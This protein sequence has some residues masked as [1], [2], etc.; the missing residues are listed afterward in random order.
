M[1][2]EPWTKRESETQKAYSRFCVYRDM[3]PDRSI[4]KVCEE[5]GKPSGYSRHL[6]RWSSEHNWVSRAESYD[7]Y[8]SERMR[9]ELE[10]K[11]IHDKV[12]RLTSLDSL[13]HVINDALDDLDGSDLSP[14]MLEKL[15]KLV[16]QEKRKEYDD[17]PTQRV[18]GE[19]DQVTTF[20]LPDNGRYEDHE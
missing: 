6:E 10:T 19:V 8:M 13:H 4:A 20:Q 11:R 9:E 16:V 2:D 5:I 17:E 15:L 3:G 18:K 12:E 14:G 1:P 7:T